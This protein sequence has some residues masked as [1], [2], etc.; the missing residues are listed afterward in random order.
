MSTQQKALS[1][2]QKLDLAKQ[3]ITEMQAIFNDP[4]RLDSALKSK[5][6]LCEQT[7]PQKTMSFEHFRK[8]YEDDVSENT[9]FLSMCSVFHAVYL[10]ASSNII[11]P[12]LTQGEAEKIQLTLEHFEDEVLPNLVFF[13]APS[14]ASEFKNFTRFAK[15]GITTK[16]EEIE[17]QERELQGGEHKMHPK[18]SSLPT[19]SAM[20]RQPAKPSANAEDE[21]VY[22]KY[23]RWAFFGVVGIAAGALALKAISSGPSAPSP[24]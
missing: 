10:E 8:Q 15:Q 23:G 6:I 7:L 11:E 14:K 17:Q 9:N 24:K 13:V 20:E 16:L 18:T 1:N 21:N 22:A 4:R 2:L 19:P 12:F 5:D 3:L